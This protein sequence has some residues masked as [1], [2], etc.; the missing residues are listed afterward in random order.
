M[1]RYIRDLNK[2]EVSVELINES[3]G[4]S[5]EG[6][7]VSHWACFC[8]AYRIHVGSDIVEI[9]DEAMY[10]GNQ[11]IVPKGDVSGYV[12][13][14]TASFR[15]EYEDFQETAFENDKYAFSQFVVAN[16]SAN[17]ADALQ[18]LLP[19]FSSCPAVYNQTFSVTLDNKGLV[20]SAIAA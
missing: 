2:E 18:R 4:A 7:W 5:F 15:S 11:V 9:V 14:Q 3:H 6:D 10:D 13:A 1:Y 16:T 19:N 12:V 8:D 17:P 20:A